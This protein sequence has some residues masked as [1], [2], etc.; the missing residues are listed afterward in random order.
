MLSV[1]I[2]MLA[3]S[4]VGS[5]AP[6][7]VCVVAV[8]SAAQAGFFR[9]LGFVLGATI[10]Y[11]LMVILVGLGL[12]GSLQRQPAI[13]EALSWIG[14]AYLLYLAW[15]IG[16]SGAAV[17]DL[18]EQH[19][20]PGFWAGAWAQ[21]LNPKAWLFSVSG[22][23]M[24]VSSA[25]PGAGYLAIFTLLS[26]LMCLLGVGSWALAGHLLGRRLSGHP[27]LLWFNPL[28]GLLL[29]GSVGLILTH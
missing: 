17:M 11:T 24:F 23:G 3:F 6:G 13:M 27:A 1:I 10:G 9:A 20:V 16:T 21:W 26:L 8:S 25:E 29:A 22:I 28:M 7:P 18:N 15:R 4:L 2:S 14:A 12:L 5:I 19:K